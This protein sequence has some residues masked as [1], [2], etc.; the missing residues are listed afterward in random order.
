[1]VVV[2]G[3]ADV[4]PPTAISRSAPSK[5]KTQIEYCRSSIALRTN[6]RKIAEVED[7]RLNIKHQRRYDSLPS[8]I[9]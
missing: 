4:Q 1:M 8:F 6:K 7:G 9:A 2:Y 3:E 5:L